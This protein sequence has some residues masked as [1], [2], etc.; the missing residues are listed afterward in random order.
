MP[1]IQTD[2]DCLNA[3]QI[4]NLAEP[5]D[6][7]DAVRLVDLA[8]Y[9]A[10][11]PTSQLWPGRRFFRTDHDSGAGIGYYLSS[12]LITWIPAEF[13]QAGPTLPT[14]TWDGRHFFYTAVIDNGAVNGTDRGLW[15]TWDEVRGKWLGPEEQ[16]EFNESGTLSTNEYMRYG[17][18][19]TNGVRGPKVPFAATLT[20]YA[21]RSQTV[22]AGDIT[23][24]N[25]GAI[26]HTVSNPG[27]DLSD[28]SLNVDMAI[29]NILQVR[30][31]TLTTSASQASMILKFRR[32][33]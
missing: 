27:R 10:A 11:F 19:R 14:T 18:M 33:F 23:I 24:R 25:L 6:D 4:K 1:Q 13:S 7:G 26:L 8:S 12:D 32:L 2:L 22:C 16:V 30:A 29:R 5:V 15:A 17:V 31:E 3:S 9:G 28:N 21:W 20:G